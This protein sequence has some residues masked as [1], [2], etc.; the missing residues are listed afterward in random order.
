LNQQL[1]LLIC[2]RSPLEPTS[3]SSRSRPVAVVA[4]KQKP[5]LKTFHAIVHVT[6]VEQWCVEAETAEEAR[7]LLAAGAGHRCEIGDC[8]N[9]EVEHVED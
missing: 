9:V 7:E 2:S 4:L 3:D 8:V 1:A 6:R 5:L